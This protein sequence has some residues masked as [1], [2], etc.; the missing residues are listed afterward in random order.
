MN[1]RQI[2]VLVFGASGMLGQGVLREC[3]QDP[4]VAGVT[5]IGRTSSALHNPKLREI[6]HADLTD[7]S[8][9]ENQL[10]N[11][12]ACFF[13]LGVSSAGLTEGAYTHVTYDFTLAAAATL[14]RLNPQMT[15]IYVSGAG[16]DSSGAGRV[17]W[18]RVK[19]RTENALLA[20]PFRAAY[21]LR[22]G[23]IQPLDGIKSKTGSYRIFYSSVGFLLPLLRAAFPNHVLS[24]RQI[25]HAMLNLAKD[26]YAKAI[27]ES[28]DINIVAARREHATL[29]PP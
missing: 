3:L 14:A 7:Y 22:P 6:R 2:N 17:M 18:A 21:M 24:T 15:F 11:F 5:T 13:C 27:L 10:A 25:G 19:G 20:L 1:R 12:D 9:I 28:R 8:S 23:I 4:D 26:G 16:T 29:V